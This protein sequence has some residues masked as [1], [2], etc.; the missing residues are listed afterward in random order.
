MDDAKTHISYV[1]VTMSIRPIRPLFAHKNI[2][3]LEV[4][5]E[6]LLLLLH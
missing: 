3:W 1:V 5:L 2:A 6:V 4:L